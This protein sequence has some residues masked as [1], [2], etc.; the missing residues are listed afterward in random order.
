MQQKELE[1]AKVRAELDALKD[2]TDV[3]AVMATLQQH[4]EDSARALGQVSRLLDRIS[5]RI[6]KEA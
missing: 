4:A 2:R 5:K 6:D 3:S 1:I